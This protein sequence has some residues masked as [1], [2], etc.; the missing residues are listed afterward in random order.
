MKFAGTIKHYPDSTLIV[1]SYETDTHIYKLLTHDSTDVFEFFY[2]N[3]VGSHRDLKA[4]LP[5]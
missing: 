5:S 1:A 4:S 2:G 3:I